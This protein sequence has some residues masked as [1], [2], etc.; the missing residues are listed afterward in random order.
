MA[1]TPPPPPRKGSNNNSFIFPTEEANISVSN[2][3]FHNFSFNTQDIYFSLDTKTTEMPHKTFDM[4]S[5]F[6]EDKVSYILKQRGI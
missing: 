5:C 2:I 1:I 6:Y 3:L 4:S